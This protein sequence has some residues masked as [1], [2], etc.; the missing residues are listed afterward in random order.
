MYLSV[1][2]LNSFG[3][4]YSLDRNVLVLLLTS[5]P[6]PPGKNVVH[7]LIVTLEDLYNG[8]TRKLAVQKNAICDKCEGEPP[9]LPRRTLL[10]NTKRVP[11]SERHLGPQ[12]HAA[13]HTADAT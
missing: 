7:Q 3:K 8:A 9:V 10:L 5:A 1:S 12:R 13:S 11:L 4:G 2:E 6:P